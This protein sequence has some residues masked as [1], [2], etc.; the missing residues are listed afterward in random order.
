MWQLSSL[1]SWYF[2]TCE[3]TRRWR[4]TQLW[5][6]LQQVFPPKGFSPQQET[7]SPPRGPAWVKNTWTLCCFWKRIS[8]NF[9]CVFDLILSSFSEVLTSVLN[10]AS[11]LFLV[12]LF[13]CFYDS[14]FL[15]LFTWERFFKK[16]N[17]FVHTQLLCLKN[18][19]SLFNYPVIFYCVWMLW[20]CVFGMLV[21]LVYNMNHF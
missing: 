13:C 18:L 8:N 15:T 2:E 5:Q 21:I 14:Y 1:V 4:S 10:K 3:R 16:S 7:S 20:K 12:A 9:S 11:L 19:W 17:F 6:I